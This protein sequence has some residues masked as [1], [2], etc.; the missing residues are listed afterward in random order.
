MIDTNCA[1]TSNFSL[2]QRAASTNRIH[3]LQCAKRNALVFLSSLYYFHKLYYFPIHPSIHF[4]VR[5][6]SQGSQPMYK[7]FS[8]HISNRGRMVSSHN[9]REYPMFI[10]EDYLYK[11]DFTCVKYRIFTTFIFFST[12]N[13]TEFNWCIYCDFIFSISLHLLE[14]WQT[15]ACIMKLIYLYKWLKIELRRQP[16]P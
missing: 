11:S 6:S 5:L 10:G 1:V 4:P 3:S 15:G 9:T 8:W 2:K 16:L 13:D 12:H 7:T 14:K